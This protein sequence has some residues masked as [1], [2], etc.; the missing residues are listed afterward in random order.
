[1]PLEPLEPQVKK[2]I[3][4]LKVHQA[5]MVML[6]LKVTKELLGH[7]DLKEIKDNKEQQDL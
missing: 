6:A 3:R 2:E 7:K 5:L 4:D 1:M